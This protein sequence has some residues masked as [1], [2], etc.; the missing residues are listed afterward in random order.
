MRRL[1]LA[2]CSLA[3]LSLSGCQGKPRPEFKIPAEEASRENPVKSTAASIAEGNQDYLMS[4]CVV[5][6]AKNG[7][8]KG[9]MS[10]ASSY[11]CRDWRDPSSLQDFTDGQLFYIINKGKGNM[12]GYE[13]R[14]NP[15]QVWLMVDFIRSLGKQGS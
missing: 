15:Q 4:N 13:R 9:F 2:I 1:V 3:F 11:N 10:G 5:C 7:S 12:P 14:L 8:G 6:H